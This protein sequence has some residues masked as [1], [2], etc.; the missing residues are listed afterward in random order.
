MDEGIEKLG[1]REQGVA[2]PVV[3]LFSQRKRYVLAGPVAVAT[4]STTNRYNENGRMINYTGS[5]KNGNV[6]VKRETE[7]VTSE[8]VMRKNEYDAEAAD[9]MDDNMTP[10]VLE[11]VISARGSIMIS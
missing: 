5:D 7:Y 1:T 6:L 9:Y 8:K 10:A 4:S 3:D 11:I 2:E